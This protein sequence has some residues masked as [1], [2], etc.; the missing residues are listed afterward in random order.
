VH[1]FAHKYAL[2]RNRR[3]GGSG[4]LFE[5]RFVSSPLVEVE[6]VARMTA[7]IDLN[8][9]TAHMV[10]RPEEHIWSTCALHCGVPEIARIDPWLWTPSE[11]Y[12]GLGETPELRAVRYREWLVE[13]ASSEKLPDC[14][15]EKRIA[16]R[17]AQPAYTRRLR[18][19][20]GQSAADHSLAYGAE[21]QF[22]HLLP[23]V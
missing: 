12:L 17:D 5:E 23:E 20:N 4:K 1:S 11:W 8:A 13:Y 19:P 7:Y 2:Y 16:E 3:R 15:R 21:S 14:V 9:Y 22:S 6:Q 10:R 18:R